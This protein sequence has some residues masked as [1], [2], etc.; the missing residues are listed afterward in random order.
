MWS[1]RVGKTESA[2][3]I[4]QWQRVSQSGPETLVCVNGMVKAKIV[5]DLSTYLTMQYVKVLLWVAHT[6]KMGFFVISLMYNMCYSIIICT[7]LY[8]HKVV[9]S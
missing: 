3:A 6:A 8:S 7:F 5:S 4:D 1:T 2:S 9:K